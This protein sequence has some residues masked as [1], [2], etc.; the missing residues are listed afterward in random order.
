MPMESTEHS[1]GFSLIELLAVLVIISILTLKGAGYV[2]KSFNRMKAWSMLNANSTAF[3][4]AAHFARQQAQSRQEFITI[5]PICGNR[6]DSGWI[7]FT[8]PQLNFEESTRANALLK[9][10]P[11]KDITT[12]LDTTHHHTRYTGNG[13]EDISV[14]NY[15]HACP[16]QLLKNSSG[17]LK[18]IS[19]NPAG[20]AQMKN[21]GLVANRLIFLSREFP[22]MQQQVIMGAG[23]RLRICTPSPGNLECR[24]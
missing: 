7:I 21:G 12:T 4:Q 18:H 8:N 2:I 13:F 16:D 19:F 10:I 17:K 15:Q 6:W 11:P 20:G 5:S 23:G 24:Q 14:A 3:I 22:D 9:Y 1:L